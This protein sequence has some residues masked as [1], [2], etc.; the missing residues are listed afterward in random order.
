MWK[1]M[2]HI[3][4]GRAGQVRLQDQRSVGRISLLAVMSDWRSVDE[5]GDE[6]G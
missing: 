2:E 6:I 3:N 5:N 4:P 1:D